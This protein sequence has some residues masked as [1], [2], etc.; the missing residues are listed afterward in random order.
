[1]KNVSND[2]ESVPIAAGL[3]LKNDA[4]EEAGTGLERVNVSI[5]CRCFCV[6]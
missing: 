6:F 4:P 3:E 1:M 2:V 5:V